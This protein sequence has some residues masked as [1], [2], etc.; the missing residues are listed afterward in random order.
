MSGFLD[1]DAPNIEAEYLRYL[2]RDIL[3]KL[4][5]KNFRLNVI[6]LSESDLRIPIG[7]HTSYDGRKFLGDAEV[8]IH[9]R[10][11]SVEIKCAYIGVKES[12]SRKTPLRYWSFGRLLNT[13]KK[14]PKIPF[15]LAFC[16]GIQAA[17]FFPLKC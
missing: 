7:R 1:K 14:R 10:W 15:E 3:G 13:V 5:F 2:D 12:D 4:L 17:D 9:E 16:I 11:G 6:G 8:R